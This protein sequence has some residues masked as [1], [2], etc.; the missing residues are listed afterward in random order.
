[1]RLPVRAALSGA[2]L[3]LGVAGPSHAQLWRN[4]DFDGFD[5]LASARIGLDFDAR[6]YDNFIVSGSGWHITSLYGEFLTDFVPDA[7]YW[8][9]R[10]G[11]SKGL[12]GTLLHAVTSSVIDFADLG[13]FDGGLNHLAIR[14]GGFE[15]FDIGP[16]MYWLTIAPVANAGQAYL[17][18]TDGMNG[19]N[20][21]GDTKFFWDAPGFAEFNDEPDQ[22]PVF[23]DFS[24]GL[25]GEEIS[26]VPE[27]ST[28]ILMATGIGAI[29]IARFRRKR[30]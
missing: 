17:G 13:D 2:V 24:Y 11:V 26:T 5:G 7:A 3:V 6:V 10:S 8:E 15:P 27:P 4:G 21:V 9:I 1:M 20:A 18:T 28:I 30:T 22:F 16:G 23:T 19:I 12:G 29:A 25:D 14:V